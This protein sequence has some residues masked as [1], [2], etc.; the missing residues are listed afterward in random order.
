MLLPR[1]GYGEGTEKGRVA[2]IELEAKPK[3][4]MEIIIEEFKHEIDTSNC[5][6][7]GGMCE[8]TCKVINGYSNCCIS[9]AISIVRNKKDIPQKCEE[10]QKPCWACNEVLKERGVI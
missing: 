7:P 1:K 5:P 2:M 9:C 3:N 6:R 8:Y 4:M 10:C